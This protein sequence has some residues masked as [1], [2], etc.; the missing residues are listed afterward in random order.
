MEQYEKQL[1]AAVRA[2]LRREPSP[3][4]LTEQADW[5]RLWR[6]AGEQSVLPMAA[7]ALADCPDLPGAVRREAMLSVMAQVR[8]ADAFTRR[9]AALEQAGLTP[10]VVKGAVCRGLYPKPDLRPSAD[11]DLLAPP[12][13]AR[14]IA[15]LLERAGMTVENPDAEQVI[16]C[17]DGASGLYLEVHGTL[18][19]ALS[20]AY[21]SWNRFFNGAFDRRVFWKEAGVWTLCP[22]DHLLYLILHSL[23]HFLHSGF[24]VRQVCD[25]CLFTAAYGGEVD[26]PALTAAL[27]QVHGRLF[28][29]NLL[30]MGREHLGISGYPEQAEAWLAGMDTDCGDLLADLLSGGVYGGNTEQRKHSS[31]ITLSAVTGEGR[32]G[33]GRLLRTLFPR[34]RDLTGTYP[35]L[36]GRPWLTPAAWAVRLLRYG[37]RSSGSDARESVSIGERRVAL[38]K[39]YGVIP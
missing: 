8:A 16:A 15:A 22:Q 20:E 10:L 28:Y 31:R 18:F 3:A 37:R 11:E 30:A 24:G 25:I 27:D 36:K 32:T 12:G 21:G 9:Y 19:P 17:R 23:K 39:K 34:G 35:W 14:N 5:V 6:L 13:Q 1:L 4:L 2:F 33:P 26:W 38:L 29:A 7:D